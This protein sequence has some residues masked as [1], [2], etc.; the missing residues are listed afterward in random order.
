MDVDKPARGAMHSAT[1]KSL[2]AAFKV[3]DHSSPKIPKLFFQKSSIKKSP[4]PI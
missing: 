4:I 3:S 2:D 1:R